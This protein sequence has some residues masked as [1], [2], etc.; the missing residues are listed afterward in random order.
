MLMESD[1]LIHID[2]NFVFCSFLLFTKCKATIF[3]IKQ[4]Q[5]SND[6]QILLIFSEIANRNSKGITDIPEPRW[7]GL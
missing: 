3:I 4:V 2:Y 1:E 6:K 5:T 7:T